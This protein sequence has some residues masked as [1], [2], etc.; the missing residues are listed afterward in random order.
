MLLFK[1]LCEGDIRIIPF[2]D[3]AEALKAFALNI[4]EAERGIAADFAKLQIRNISF[5]G[6]VG[7]F[8]GFKLSGEA[9]SIPARNIRGFKARHILI[10]YDKIL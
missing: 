3:N 10:S 2:A 8:S 9:V 5:R 7:F 6:N 4:N 1:I